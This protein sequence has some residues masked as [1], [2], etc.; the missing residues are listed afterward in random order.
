MKDRG[1]G[2]NK[3]VENKNSDERKIQN[4]SDIGREGYQRALDILH[5]CLRDDGFFSDADGA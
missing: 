5:H 4:S 3:S 2:I 1:N